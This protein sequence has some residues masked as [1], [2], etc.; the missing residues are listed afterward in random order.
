MALIKI[1]SGRINSLNFNFTGHNTAA[2][3]TVVMTYDNLKVDVL[4]RDKNTN[5]IKKRG[6]V[7]LVANFVV[8]NDNPMN[9][10]LRESNPEY[11]R[12]EYKSFFNLVWKTLYTGMKETVG[13][14]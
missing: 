4:K 3:G 5:D 14:P 7:T 9:G 13:M 11:E 2:K 10:T 8:K 6:L 12:N 1:K